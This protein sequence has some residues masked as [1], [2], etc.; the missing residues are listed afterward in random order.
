M[1]TIILKCHVYTCKNHENDSDRCSF[2]SV[3]L[4]IVGKCMEKDR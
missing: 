3:S 4:D 1:K 2:G